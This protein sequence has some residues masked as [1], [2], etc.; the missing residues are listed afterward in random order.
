MRKLREEN[1]NNVLFMDIETAPKWQLLKDAPEEVR[2]EWIQKFKYNDKCPP[3]GC[4]EY[5][6]FFSDLWI[7]SAGLYAEFSRV[8]VI[9]MGFLTRDNTFRL[10]S[11]KDENER[12]LLDE[13]VT[14][15]DSFCFA[16][17]YAKFCAHYGKGFDYP[18][19]AK[20]LLI[21][22]R[23]LPY[24]L[25]NYGL[26]P[27]ESVNLDTWEIWKNGS[28]G[29]SGTLS[30]IATAFGL[31][32]PKEDIDG[33]DVSRCYHN[34]ELDRIAEYC[35]RD[36]FTLLNVFKCMRAEEP[37]TEDAIKNIVL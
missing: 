3:K 6:D 26:K 7:K 31:P 8:V 12:H 23:K 1:I 36:V 29:N 25:D 14:D 10:K 35:E 19:L 27:W 37:L 18:Y 11:Y 32:S 9:S 22:R 33:G 24:L 21:H 5:E 20:R 17:K 13:F 2:K 4:Q 15:L 34:G 30:S 28:L 16:N